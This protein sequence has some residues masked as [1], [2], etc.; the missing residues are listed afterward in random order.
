MQDVAAH[1]LS[2]PDDVR[3]RVAR[4]RRLHGAVAAAAHREVAAA[5]VACRPPSGGFYLY[6][7]FEA[8][9]DALAAEGVTTGAELAEHLL[10]RHDVGVLAGEA[11]GDDAAAL[12]VRMAT[13]LLYGRTDDERHE[14]LASDDPAALPWIRASLDRLR[15]VLDALA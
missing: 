9:R 13:S 6:P 8:M 11:F 10:E 4:S 5:G 12:R 7:D 2:E 3:E 15:A 14:A 1:V